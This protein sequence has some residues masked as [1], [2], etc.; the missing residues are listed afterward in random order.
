M[1]SNKYDIFKQ[2][3]KIQTTIFIE[4]GARTPLRS[5]DWGQFNKAKK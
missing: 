5:D 3:D 1:L 2:S 4:L